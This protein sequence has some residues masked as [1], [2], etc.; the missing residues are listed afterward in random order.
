M[1]DPLRVSFY[2]PEVDS[3]REVE[4]SFFG[5]VTDIVPI[6]T[7][8]TPYR[9]QRAA[10][11]DQ[12]PTVY[13]DPDLTP[14]VPGV[15]DQDSISDWDL[16]FQLDREIGSEDDQYWNE[17]R[18]TPKA[19]LP[20]AEGR[21]LF[22]SRFGDTTSIRIDANVA[23][24]TEELA[25]SIR[26]ALEP[27]LE[28]LGWSLIPIREQ[29]LAASRGTTPFDALFLSLS[30]FVIL[31]AVMLIAML[32]R[33]GLVERTRQFGTLMAVGWTPKRVAALT[34]LE[35][36]GVASVG[37]VLGAIGGVWYARFVLWAL[38]TW[39]VGA[40]TVPFLEFHWSPWSVAIGIL[41]GWLVSAIAIVVTIRSLLRVDAQTLLSGRD[42]TP[43]SA[44]MKESG[45][46]GTGDRAVAARSWG[47][48]WL[49]VT[50]LI[51]FVVAL[52][53]AG[54]GASASGQ[55]AA[56]G[57]VGAG[58]LLLIAALLLI[59]H[60]LRRPRRIEGLPTDGSWPGISLGRL[61]AR[62]ASRHPIRST[63]SIGLMAAAAF[64]IVAM[65][66]FRLQPSDRG[67]GG[68]ALLGTTSQPLFRDLG[69]PAIRSDLLGADAEA[70]RQVTVAAFR[71][72]PGQDASCNNLYQAIQPTVLGIPSTFGDL[73]RPGDR[74]ADAGETFPGFE[75]S[76]TASLTEDSTP[77][78][79]LALPAS[80]SQED[81]IPM[82]IDQNTAMWSLQMREGVG[83]TRSFEYESGKPIHFRVVGLLLNSILQGQLMIG[84]TNFEA[85][86]PAIN[87]YRFFLFG[88]GDG[89]L[90]S[91]RAILENRLGD[92]GMD[93]QETRA[94][95]SSLLAVQNTYLR[96]FQSLG[97][98]GLLL[99]TVGLAVTQMRSVLERRR[100]LAVMRAIGFT[101]GRLAKLVL[102]ETVVLLMAGIGCGVLCAVLAVLP[103]AVAN[104]IRPPILEPLAVVAGVIL[105]GML[106]GL[107]A[108]RRVVT[109]PLLSSLRAE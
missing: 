23:E 19:F 97:A 29:Q 106:A 26:A 92:V 4:R 96:T 98:L 27:V 107:L 68:F 44:G 71:L 101:R 81:P 84:E 104:S 82:I 63:L 7:P 40:V 93:V 91:R 24:T 103:Y 95:L 5:V 28:D 56:A 34:F 42:E 39:W 49:R 35:G 87:G 57:F 69:D 73:F 11:F 72:R 37:V 64:L 17:H 74:A 25:A 89:D 53:V 6:T 33:L 77:W 108:V 99:G 36:L 54:F 80:G 66:A 1:G 65:S 32:F 10:T 20:L 9:L 43:P 90:E 79:L 51:T 12:P 41:A 83:E 8:A 50:A 62:S 18:L 47:A 55:E 58:M 75:W 61:A 59:H 70:F 88:G 102:G 2:E 22:G 15:T 76:A 109:L 45:T 86:F 21:R 13:N 3:G 85:H 16:P 30:L 38:R 78:D 105:F 31:A 14:T 48:S 67:T 94:V 100:E 46:K 60:R 52:A